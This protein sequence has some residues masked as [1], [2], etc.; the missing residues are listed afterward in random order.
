MKRIVKNNFVYIKDNFL[1][2]KK[3]YSIIKKYEKNLQ[4]NKVDSF[5]NYEY[6]DFKENIFLDALDKEIDQYKNLYPEINLTSSCWGLNNL[7]LKKFNINK[8]FTD[9]HSEHSINYPYRVLNVQIYLTEHNC[10]TEFYNGEIIKSEIG[11]LAIFP[12][13]FTHTHRGQICKE[14][15]IRYLIT[16]YVSFFKKGV[17]ENE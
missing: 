1:S 15:K 14:N 6:F 4:K 2:L 16:G 10:G 9:W 8:G 7:R 13:Y 17:N 12:S 5:L 11:R 3:C